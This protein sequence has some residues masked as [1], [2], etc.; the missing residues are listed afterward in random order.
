M[1][2]PFEKKFSSKE[3]NLAYDKMSPV[4]QHEFLELS[5]KLTPD[6]AMKALGVKKGSIRVPIV[7]EYKKEHYCKRKHLMGK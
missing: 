4:Q 7:P 3:I 5:S 6:K 2:N 1:W